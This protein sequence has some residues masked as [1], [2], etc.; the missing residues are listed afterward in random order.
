[1]L[2]VVEHEQQVLVLQESFQLLQR[3]LRPVALQSEC[4]G[5]GGKDQC[6]IVDGGQGDEADPVG[7]VILHLAR[8]LQSQARLA[9]AAGAGEGEQAYLRAL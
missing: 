2:E 9:H 1:M 8:D 5:H 7:E 6:G 4:S 3:G